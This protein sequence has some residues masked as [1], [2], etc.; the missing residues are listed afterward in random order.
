[1]SP[2]EPVGRKSTEIMADGVSVRSPFSM[3]QRNGGYG[4]AGSEHVRRSGTP[5]SAMGVDGYAIE[6]QMT[7]SP[8]SRVPSGFEPAR[9]ATQS[10]SFNGQDRV[11]TETSHAYRGYGGSY[12]YSQ[13]SVAPPTA[14]Y[15]P[16]QHSSGTP[17]PPQNAYGYN[18]HSNASHQSNGGNGGGWWSGEA[19]TDQPQE[20]T[21]QS[22]DHQHPQFSYTASSYEPTSYEPDTNSTPTWGGANDN[23]DLGFGNSKPKKTDTATPQTPV[24]NTATVSQAESEM[25]DASLDGKQEKQGWGIFSLFSR[26]SAPVASKEDKKAVKANLGEQN[27]FY[28]DEKEKRWVNR[29]ADTKPAT[30]SLPP[31]PKSVSLDSSRVSSPAMPPPPSTPSLMSNTPPV[32]APPRMNSAPISATASPP[33]GSPSVGSPSMSTPPPPMAGKRASAVGGRKPMRSRYVDVFNQAPPS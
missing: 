29:S 18:N 8:Y 28:Y 11:Q 33:I 21:V 30:T 20:E 13:D 23:D 4:G 31:P 12:G 14:N 9:N 1:M 10:P 16:F 27:Q 2:A 25:N 24:E 19:T 17:I 32:A 26:S 7:S 15:S 5:S 22:G 3:D 6:R